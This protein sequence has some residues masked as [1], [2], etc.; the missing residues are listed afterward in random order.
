MLIAIVTFKTATA[1]RP[2][3]IAT[4]LDEGRTVRA[5]PGCIR[6]QPL[7]DPADDMQTALLH[8]WFDEAAFA[9]YTASPGFADVGV[10]L[11]P[12]MT[13]PPVSRRFAASLLATPD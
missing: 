1:D 11:R 5:M 10:I 3:A 12:L 6:F 7:A 2:K 9:A 4:L 13:E 8:E